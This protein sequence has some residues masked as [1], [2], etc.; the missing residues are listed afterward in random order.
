[1]ILHSLKGSD[2]FERTVKEGRFA[3]KGNL[4]L[5]VLENGL[6]FSR[7][8]VS[9]SLKAG[10]SVARN[11]FRRWAREILRGLGSSVS[12][13]WD[14]VLFVRRNDMS[15]A[16]FRSTLLYLLANRKVLASA[17]DTGTA[18]GN[19]ALRVKGSAE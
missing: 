15:F 19:P 12:P 17:E 7:F 4:A 1:M 16:E 14:I 11:R 18:S 3:V 9:V 8:G 5:Y 13:G 10:S 2:S 6:N